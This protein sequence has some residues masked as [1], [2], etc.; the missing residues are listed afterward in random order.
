MV[1][2][3]RKDQK[4][5]KQYNLLQKRIAEGTYNMNDILQEDQTEFPLRKTSLTPEMTN[6]IKEKLKRFEQEEQFRKKG[7]TQKSIALKL[8]TNSHYLSV[9]INEQKGM[10]FNRYMAELRINYITN[11]LNTNSKYL[12][13]TIEA[14]AEE[15]GIAARQ[16]FSNLFFDI[17]GIRPTDYIKNRKKEL[18]VS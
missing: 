4:I 12:N 2:R 14:L 9:Y 8:G 7:I 16:N 5:K 3:H 11:L 18:G 13:Y 15:C 6:E 17:N 10:N 1:V